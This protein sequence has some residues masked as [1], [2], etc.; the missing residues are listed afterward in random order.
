ME[1]QKIVN[2]EITK[3]IK[4]LDDQAYTKVIAS[5]LAETEKPGKVLILSN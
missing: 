3:W 5:R 2:I 4:L 1:Q